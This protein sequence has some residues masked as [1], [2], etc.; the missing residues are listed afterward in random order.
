MG[1]GSAATPTRSPARTANGTMGRDC[2]P[3]EAAHELQRLRNSL[4]VISEVTR[5]FAEATTN[6]AELL[7]SVARCLAE[8]LHDTCVVL[9]LDDAGKMLKTA[10]LHA[11]EP[12]ALELLTTSYS[13]RNLELRQHAA[14][15]HVMET[16]QARLEPKLAVHRDASDEQLTWQRKLGL[17]SALAVALRVQGRSIGVIALTRFRAGS[18]PFGSTDLELAQTLADHAG[19]ALENARL[20]ASAEEARRSAEHAE[21]RRLETA[22]R[23]ERTLD[24]MKEGYTIMDRQLRYVYVNRAGA[25]H[26]HLTREQLLGHSPLELYPGFE[27]TE[28]HLALQGALD[29]GVP[30]RVEE[31]LLHADGETGYFELAI[32]PIAEG[33]VV[34]STDQT[35]RRRAEKKRDCLEEQLR[36]AQKMEA[37]GRLAGGIAHDFNNLLSVILGYGE[38]IIADLPAGSPLCDDMREVQSA[39]QR[40]AELTKQLLLFSRQQV[41]EPKVMDLNEVVRGMDRMLSRV[42]GE[43][44]SLVLLPGQNLGRIRADRGSIEQ[45]VMNLAVNARDAMPAGGT[46]TIETANVTIDE[47]FARLH[48]GSKPGH[49]VFLGVTDSGIGMTAETRA[50][51]FEPFFSTKSQG[52]GTGLG[53]STVHGI[54][55]Q[56]GGGI[57]VYSELGRGTTVKVYLPRVDAALDASACVAE[58]ATLR[59]TETV[60]LVEDEEQVREVARRILERNGYSVLVAESPRDAISLSRSHGAELHLLLTDVVMPQMSGAELAGQIAIQ[61]PELKVL[62]M[63]GYTDG[64]I[65]SQGVL[66]EGVYFVQKP[67][68]SE[69]LAGKVRTVLDSCASHSLVS[70]T[71]RGLERID[72][73]HARTNV[74]DGALE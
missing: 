55:Q 19:L 35:E 24:S 29:S 64:T 9:L 46:L 60:L 69:L 65:L 33:L 42:L 44:L 27:G 54:V 72:A 25:E 28:I 37:V 7:Q 15:A 66:G 2:S 14:L 10:S 38:G 47:A 6:Y 53:L 34:L 36:Q 21:T 5:R 31:Q 13:G 26:T 16:G 63:S 32:Q 17:H 73:R 45:V 58:P 39:A 52:K 8:A 74:G 56:A 22:E 51:V 57:W 70:V 18:P 67:F 41:L 62:F 40:A 11:V 61:R 3:D 59:G 30:T 1:G 68:T 12:W 23:L 20:Y 4:R 48:V 43:H 49:Y 50:R 71:A